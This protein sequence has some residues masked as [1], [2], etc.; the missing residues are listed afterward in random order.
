MD[1]IEINGLRCYG[2]TGY[3][4]EEQVLG[5]WFEINVRISFD[6]RK[7]GQSDDLSDTLDYR[8]VIEVIK[9]RVAN[10]KYALIERLIEVIAQ[11]ILKKPHIEQVSLK[12]TKL[13]PPIPDFGGQISLEITRSN[14]SCG[15][16]IS[17]KIVSK[18]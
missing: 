11:D 8:E 1:I 5:Q 4:T 10:S 15:L 9:Q 14:P 17:N 3:F 18:S 16:L 13:S 2:Y 6:L 7:A 12:L